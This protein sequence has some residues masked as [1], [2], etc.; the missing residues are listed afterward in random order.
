MPQEPTIAITVRI[1]PEMGAAIDAKIALFSSATG[2]VF[3]KTDIVRMALA[4]YLE[5]VPKNGDQPQPTP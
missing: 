4:K 3:S 2:A 5:M 1:S